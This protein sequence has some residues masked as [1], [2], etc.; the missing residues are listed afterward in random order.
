MQ[1]AVLNVH[2]VHRK[3]TLPERS[4]ETFTEFKLFLILSGAG[5]VADILT[6]LRAEQYGVRNPTE[7][8]LFSFVPNIQTGSVAHTDPYSTGTAFPF[9]E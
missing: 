9:R 2:T 5:S 6:R 1:Y 7:T 4:V 8:K 3:T